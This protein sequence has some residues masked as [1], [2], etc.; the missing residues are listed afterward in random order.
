MR[1]AV[2]M[3]SCALWSAAAE[4]PQGAHVLLRLENSISTRTA[5]EGDYVY[6]RTAAPIAADG[7]IL[8]PEGSYVQGEVTHSVRSGRVKGRAEL[9]IRID[10]LTLPGG[11]VIKLAPRLASVDSG[12]TEQKVDSEKG[13]EQGSS[14]GAD[15]A[16]VAEIGGTG[17]A[18]G[19]LAT[20]T[21][22]GAGIGAGAGGAV[23]LAS[24]L[25]TRG[26]EVDLRRGSTMD[27]VFDRPVPVD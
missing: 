9:A 27:V 20:R 8:V 5:R 16:R 22:S 14:K 17:A 12:G 15:A 21:W 3:I 4:I 6:M 11:K 13:I 10:T 19:G 1:I 25:L 18:I 7:R 26:R 23:G 24:V 2:L